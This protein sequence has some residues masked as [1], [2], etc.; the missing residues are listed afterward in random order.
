M[1]GD[2]SKGNFFEP[3]VTEGINF[4]SKSYNVE[5]FGPVFNLYRLISSKECIDYA[6]KSDYGLVGTIFTEDL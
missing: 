5:F 2:L 3:L 6:N 1:S 4:Y